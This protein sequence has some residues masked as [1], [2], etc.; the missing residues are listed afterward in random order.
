MVLDLTAQITQAQIAF[1]LMVIAV[2]ITYYV[3]A[4]KPTKSDW[5]DKK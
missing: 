2:A 4:K 1:A 5:K 3:F